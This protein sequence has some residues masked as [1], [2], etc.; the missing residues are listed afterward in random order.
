MYNSARDRARRAR[1]VW[2]FHQNCHHRLRRL[3][4]ARSLAL[5]LRAFC[6]DTIVSGFSTMAGNAS[7]DEWFDEPGGDNFADITDFF[8]AAGEGTSHERPQDYEM[9]I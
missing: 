2:S 1:R 8:V 7:Y 9:Y 3:D 5:R 4:C 6:L